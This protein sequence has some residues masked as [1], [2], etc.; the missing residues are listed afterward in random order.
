MTSPSLFIR[1]GKKFVKPFQGVFLI[2]HCFSMVALLL[3]VS[4]HTWL[5]VK[6]A[7]GPV[8]VHSQ[9][10]V[11]MGHQWAHPS[12][13]NCSVCVCFSC[14]FTCH[15]NCAPLCC[16]G[17][18]ALIF[19]TTVCL[20]HTLSLSLSLV[21]SLSPSFPTHCLLCVYVCV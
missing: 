10:C 1:G 21:R 11:S 4:I 6:M 13:Q 7:S 12:H 18:L 9:W 16:D 2:K 17:S 3:A 19:V 8:I 20:P 5:C 14:S 15:V